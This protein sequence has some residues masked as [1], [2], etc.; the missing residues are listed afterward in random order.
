MCDPATI[1]IVLSAGSSIMSGMAAQGAANANAK[2]AQQNA[3]NAREQ[4]NAVEQQKAREL[5]KL[6]QQKREFMGKQRVAGAANGLN[7]QSGSGLNLLE[8]TEVQAQADEDTLEWNSALK[9]W[10]Y[11]AQAV[12][13]DNQASQFKTQGSNAMISGIIGAATSVAGGMAKNGGGNPAASG[14]NMT[15]L[16]NVGGVQTPFG[17]FGSVAKR[18]T[19]GQSYIPKWKSGW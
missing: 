2:A 3:A 11:D 8:S 4:A 17:A 15:N 14:Y 18:W 13:Y 19:N 12:N 9:K 6:N 1:G 5:T 7:M 10:G 16:P